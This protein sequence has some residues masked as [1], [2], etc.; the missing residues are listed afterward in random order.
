MA[1]RSRVRFR[2][3]QISRIS[4][5]GELAS[6]R[7]NPP[8]INWPLEEL[9]IY[10]YDKLYV[11]LLLFQGTFWALMIGFLCGITRM[12]LD[13]VYRKPKCGEIDQRPSIIKNFH[14]MY[15]ALLIF[16]ITSIACIIISL[17][18]E[19]P[20]PEMVGRISETL[21]F[22]CWPDMSRI[23]KTCLR[24]KDRICNTIA[25]VALIYTSIHSN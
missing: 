11:L 12:I 25:T 3:D 1:R 15:F 10:S 22:R 16:V 19:P 6:Y 7:T 21:C 5:E 14:F 9:Y 18:T 24:N 8:H 20:D 23:L 2:C 13:F 17:F 4:P